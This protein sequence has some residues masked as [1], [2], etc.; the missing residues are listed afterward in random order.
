[1]TYSTFSHFAAPVTE[2]KA[3]HLKD[4]RTPRLLSELHAKL[5]PKLLSHTLQE[6]EVEV[7]VEVEGEEEKRKTAQ[8]LAFDG[9]V[10]KITEKQHQRL[11]EVFGRHGSDYQ[12]ADLW[13]EANPRK[14]RKNHFAFMRNWLSRAKEKSVPASKDAQVGAGPE[15]RTTFCSV[16]HRTGSWHLNAAKRGQVDHEFA[17]AV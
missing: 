15:V 12:E 7:E 10:L 1:M 13:L 14:V 9:R 11:T 4:Y 17:E 6:G 2:Q 3:L 5:Q 8:P 16:C